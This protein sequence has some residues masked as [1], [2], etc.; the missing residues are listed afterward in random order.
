LTDSER[1][2]LAAGGIAGA[3]DLWNRIGRDREKGMADLAAEYGVDLGRLEDCLVQLGERAY[4]RGDGPWLRRHWPDLFVLCAMALFASLAV[5][6]FSGKSAVTPSV[7][8][9]SSIRR[10]QVLRSNDVELRPTPTERGG[11]PFISTVVGRYAT[12]PM[13]PEEI[14]T[15]EHLGPPDIT[16]K[17][18]LDRRILAI[19]LSAPQLRS[20][21]PGDRVILVPSANEP[22]AEPPGKPIEDALVLAVDTASIVVALPEAA[23]V[24]LASGMGGSTVHVVGSA[25]ET[26]HAIEESVP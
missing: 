13:S 21:Q 3:T 20:V 8:A 2:S 12:V 10:F 14:V 11:V 1:A 15:P 6:A 19:P 23:A 9:S 26:K 22:T 24:R 25:F 16:A 4:L 5:R 7:V 18:L 17:D